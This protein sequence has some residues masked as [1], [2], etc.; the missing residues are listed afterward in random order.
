MG[1][2]PVTQGENRLRRALTRLKPQKLP[3]TPLKIEPSNPFEVAV[4]ERLDAL[5]AELDRLSSRVNWLLTVIIGFAL[6]NLVIN[7]VQ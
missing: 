7:L 5:Q 6:L 3:N 4:K 2:D 1:G